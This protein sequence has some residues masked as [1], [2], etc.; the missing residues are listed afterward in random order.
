MHIYADR[1]IEPA[2]LANAKTTGSIVLR[3]ANSLLREGGFTWTMNL[4]IGIHIVSEHIYLSDFRKL[5]T[6]GR[7][8]ES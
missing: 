3:H 7:T 4:N 1:R 5:S 2:A 8:T 6:I